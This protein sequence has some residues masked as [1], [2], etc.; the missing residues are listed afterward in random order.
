MEEDE[1]GLTYNK[2]FVDHPEMVLGKMEEVSGRFGDTLA[3]LPEDNADLK[4]MLERAGK[5]ISASTRYEEIE[6][7]DDEISFIPATDDVKNFSY[8][9]LNNEVYYRKNSLFIKKEIPD[10]NKKKIRD[11]LKLKE[12][13]KD[14]IYKQKE[15][16]SDAEI[17]ASQEILNEVYDR[18]SKKH[19]FVNNLS[20]TRALRE[21]SNF[22]LVSSIEVLDEEENFKAKGDIFSKRTISKAKVIN[23]VDTSLEALLLSISPKGY[24]DFDYIQGLTDKDR[25]TIITELKGEIFLNIREENVK[26]NQKFS[27][28]LEDG[29]LPF[30]CSDDRSTFKYTYVTKDEYLSGNIREKIGAIDSY[31]F[32]ISQAKRILSDDR[33]TEKELLDMELNRLEYQK[34]ELQKVMP[35]ELEASEINIRLGATWIPVKDIERFIF[36]TLKTPG[37]ARWNIHVKFSGFTSEWNIEGKSQDRGNDLAEMTY[38]TSRVSAYK[39]VEDALNLKETKVFDQIENP[40]GSKTSVLNK[41]ETMLAGQKQELLKEEF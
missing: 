26:T 1:K 23:H 12:A 8:T 18:F 41:K 13:L 7:L 3:C 24:V 36:E 20:N 37:Y 35:K 5:Q 29:D 15:D 32:R 14:V 10:K 6:L 2:Y 16:F 38:G 9:I 22:P 25:S 31:I 34:A 39:L 4:E 17:K 40:D 30:S 28:N 27:F 21:D 11:Y 33:E 19:G